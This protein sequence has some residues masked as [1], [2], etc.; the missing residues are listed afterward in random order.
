MSSSQLLAVVEV[1]SL[2]AHFPGGAQ[3]QSN[4][5]IELGNTLTAALMTCAPCIQILINSQLSSLRLSRRQLNYKPSCEPFRTTAN[6]I[7]HLTLSEKMRSSL[8]ASTLLWDMALFE[9]VMGTIQQTNK[10]YGLLLEYTML[11]C[12]LFSP[13]CKSLGESPCDTAD[14][15]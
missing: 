8:W 12:P 6:V 11:I 10:V 4:E 2:L 14:R 5:V 13:C 1:D 3:Y 15:R 7:M 9:Y